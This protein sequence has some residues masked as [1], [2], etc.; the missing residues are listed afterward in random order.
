MHRHHYKHAHAASYEGEGVPT[1]IR[2]REE[3]HSQLYHT[4]L[5]LFADEEFRFGVAPTGSGSEAHL[6]RVSDCQ[7]VLSPGLCKI[8][9]LIP[10]P[11]LEQSPPPF[12]DRQKGWGDHYLLLP[13]LSKSSSASSF[14]SRIPC[15]AMKL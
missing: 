4:S 9:P 5:A 15:A 1:A 8:T 12:L 7:I 13:L 10:T 6:K 14:S 2:E 3:S 11:P